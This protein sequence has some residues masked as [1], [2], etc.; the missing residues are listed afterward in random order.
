MRINFVF[1]VFLFSGFCCAQDTLKTAK[2][3]IDFSGYMD[4]YYAY[5]FN[6]SDQLSNQTFFYNHNRH[7]E[8]NINIALFRGVNY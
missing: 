7:N 6:N 5:D 2:I 8:F 1:I 4:G 3:N